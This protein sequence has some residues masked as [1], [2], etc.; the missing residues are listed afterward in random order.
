MKIANQRVANVQSMNS[1]MGQGDSPRI[2]TF[3]RA[4]TGSVREWMATSINSVHAV[5][6]SKDD[7]TSGWSSRRDGYVFM[8]NGPKVV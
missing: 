6:M 3:F 1:D 8:A 7:K 5:E 2:S 4:T